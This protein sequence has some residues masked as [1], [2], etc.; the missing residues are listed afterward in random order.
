M[1]NRELVGSPIAWSARALLLGAIVALS[2]LAV[3][4]AGAKTAAVAPAT[5]SVLTDSTWTVDGGSTS[6]A[7]IAPSCL[8][9]YGGWGWTAA[10]APA[11]WIWANACSATDTESHSFMKTFQVNGSV[12][13]ATIELA[14]DNFGTV[15]INGHQVIAELG[16][17][18]WNFRD[19]Q[20]A[21]ATA[22]VHTGSNTIVVTGQNMANGSSLGWNNPAGVIANLS[23]TYLPL[24]TS[25]DQCKN[26]GWTQYAGFKNQGD[27]VS[28]VATLGKNQPG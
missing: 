26:G 9:G 22:Y 17:G 20:S 11:Q 16:D 3:S 13:A 28:Y 18:G 27:C 25:T 19:W 6:A 15:S 8:P 2:L 4:P 1:N 23:V 5:L 24:P 14:A 12:T 21:N 7:A 10:L